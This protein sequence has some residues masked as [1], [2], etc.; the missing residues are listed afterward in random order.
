MSNLPTP[1][2]TNPAT[3][4]FNAE[5]VA[6]GFRNARKSCRGLWVPSLGITGGVL[7]DLSGNK[8]HGIRVG[9]PSWVTD[10]FLAIDDCST[11][12]YYVTDIY[13]DASLRS[14]IYYCSYGG[15][16]GNWGS[17]DS[18]GD[19][20]FGPGFQS[21]ANILQF[22]YNTTRVDR[23]ALTPVGESRVYGWSMFPFDATR[24]EVR[25]FSDGVITAYSASHVIAFCPPID[26]PIGLGNLTGPLARFINGPQHLYYLGNVA[27]TNQ[28]HMSIAKDPFGLVRN[29]KF[30]VPLGNTLGVT[31][32]NDFVINVANSLL[33]NRDTVVPNERKL[34]L[35]IDNV[36]PFSATLDILKDNAVPLS[37]VS[38]LLRDNIVNT[39]NLSE[40]EADAV[41]NTSW[42]GATVIDVDSVIN[43]EYLA[44]L[45]RDDILTQEQ[46]LQIVGTHILNTANKETINSDA[47]L[48]YSALSGILKDNV[49]NTSWGGAIGV[50]SDSIIN[51]DFLSTIEKPEL[52]VYSHRN[53]LLADFILSVAGKLDISQDSVVN[54]SYLESVGADGVQLVENLLDYAKNLEIITEYRSLFE[55]SYVLNFESNL[56][57]V[58]SKI[59]PTDNIAGILQNFIL[60]LEW[61]GLDISGIS[62]IWV[63]DSRGTT[64][65]LDSRDTDWTLDSRSTIWILDAR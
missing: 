4:A 38:S 20:S 43:L 8:H 52:V 15:G 45:N 54:T 48:A 42:K 31:A 49:I 26:N 57:V 22:R 16:E 10:K 7:W 47:V 59:L 12:D 61:E 3:I 44:S 64:W 2:W 50:T 13:P 58:V 1:S 56:D 32:Y 60:P 9:S 27:L 39:A 55:K 51:L 62:N 19:P 25:G 28:E 34:E 17:R 23:S 37:H 65:V 6:P 53:Q 24:Y 29:V 33:L 46:K 21:T 41:I 63:L 30:S 36:L 18:L 35:N 11:S 5:D 14:V 40:I